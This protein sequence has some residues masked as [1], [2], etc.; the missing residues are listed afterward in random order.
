MGGA[1]K[2]VNVVHSGLAWDMKYIRNERALSLDVVCQ[3]LK[4]QQSKL[5]RMENGQQHISDADLASLLVIYEV[6]GQ[7][8]RR[9]LHLAQRQDDPGRWELDM[10]TELDDVPDK[11]GTLLRLE[12]EATALVDAETV[13]IPGLAQTADYAG[14]MMNAAGVLPEQ[15]KRRVVIRMER[16]SLLLK[17]GAPKFDMIV[18]EAALRKI[19]GSRAIMARQLRA[20]LDLAERPNVRLW[21][22]PF[23]AS[24]NVAFYEPFYL[25]KLPR[26]KSVVLLESKGSRVFLEDQQKIDFFDRHAAKV[27]KAA[28]NPAAS[29]DF[30]ANLRKE[31]ERE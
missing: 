8:R 21:V 20:L 1:E 17:N 11:K 10:P 4:W 15:A 23:A 12:P 24:G 29:I 28:L 14:A 31:H 3:R 22:V 18:D 19:V 7:E 16:Q 26:N 6:H 25:M 2:L 5:S 27:V 13:L 30:V 9:L